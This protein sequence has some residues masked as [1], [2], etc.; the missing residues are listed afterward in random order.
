MT[1]TPHSATP[2]SASA[3]ASQSAVSGLIDTAALA[4]PMSEVAHL[5]SLLNA[6]PGTRRS[7]EQA[8]RT[9]T[10]QRPLDDVTSLVQLLSGPAHDPGTAAEAVRLAAVNR[11]VAD[12]PRLISLLSSTP[13]QSGTAD[14]AVRAAA[15]TRPLEDLVQLIGL[16]EAAAPDAGPRQPPPDTPPSPPLRTGSSAPVRPPDDRPPEGRPR[17]ALRLSAAVALAGCGA[18][19]LPSG[20]MRLHP[21]LSAGQ[22]VPLAAAV[23]CLVLA[24][25]L[26]AGRRCR[27]G[28][29]PPPPPGSGLPISWPTCM[30]MRPCSPT[31]RRRPPRRRP[32]PC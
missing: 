3:S 7:A 8:L 30:S 10:V 31:G 18:A 2:H 9:A 24:C 5:V 1:V 13:H 11:P 27:Y 4:R 19:H 16:L 29:R 28:W 26:L 32:W 20:V 22:L 17:T 12:V 15:V 23:L 25:G 21:A 6:V 14:Q